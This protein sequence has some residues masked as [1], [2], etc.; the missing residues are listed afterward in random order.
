ML[1]SPLLYLTNHDHFFPVWVVLRAFLTR[2][3]FL[4]FFKSMNSQPVWFCLLPI[5][6]IQFYFLTSSKKSIT[7]FLHQLRCILQKGSMHLLLWISTYKIVILGLHFR[8][9]KIIEKPLAVESPPMKDLA[10]KRQSLLRQN[11]LSLRQSFKAANLTEATDVFS[12][13]LPRCPLCP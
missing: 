4:L 10:S 8:I 12:P 11:Y 13:P 6:T 3:L 7:L 1:P 9:S 5:H 2:Y